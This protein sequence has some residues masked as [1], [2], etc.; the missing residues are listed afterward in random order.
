MPQ[1]VETGSPLS[2]FCFGNFT[3][4]N[5]TEDSSNQNQQNRKNQP[6]VSQR[7]PEV[8][9]KQTENAQEYSKGD[10]LLSLITKAMTHTITY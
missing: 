4:S 9:K 10:S 7:Q 5:S 3:G 2:Q 1:S 6:E 8:T